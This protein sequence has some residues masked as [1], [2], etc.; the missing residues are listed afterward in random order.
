MDNPDITE[1]E[2]ARDAKQWVLLRLLD[3]IGFTLV[4]HSNNAS[5][6]FFQNV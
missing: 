5:F 2:K 1:A 3:R 4:V 6:F